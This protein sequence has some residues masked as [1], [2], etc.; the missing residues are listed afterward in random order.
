MSQDNDTAEQHLGAHYE[1]YGSFQLEA[2]EFGQFLVPF[3]MDESTD[4]I[5]K[6]IVMLKDYDFYW[7]TKQSKPESVYQRRL[8]YILLFSEAK[9]YAEFLRDTEEVV[10]ALSEDLKAHFDRTYMGTASRIDDM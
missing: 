5:N 8:E 10:Y 9:N 4:T 2:Y 1:V 3:L 6:F 7:D